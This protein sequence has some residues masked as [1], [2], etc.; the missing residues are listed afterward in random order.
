MEIRKILVHSCFDRESDTPLMPKGCKCRRWRTADEAARL[1]QSGTYRYILASEKTVETEET[2]PTCSNDKNLKKN[3]AGCN[4]T[5]KILVTSKYPV[6]GEDII[7]ASESGKE[8]TKTVKVKRAP[9]IEKAHIQR[10]YLSG[11]THEQMRIEDYGESGFMLLGNLGA[12]VRNRKTGEIIVPGHPEPEDN[13]KT[14]S[15]RRFDYGRS[16]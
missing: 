12:E 15:G 3:C 16:L 13:E 7:L 6:L 8:N 9:T 11:S 4:R 2:C 1:V 10:G 14:G 5:G